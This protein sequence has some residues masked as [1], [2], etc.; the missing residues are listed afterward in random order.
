MCDELPLDGQGESEDFTALIGGGSNDV[1]IFLV[2]SFQHLRNF[3][4]FV[5][6]EAI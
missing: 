4:L 3:K 5:A 1:C 2:N 6:L